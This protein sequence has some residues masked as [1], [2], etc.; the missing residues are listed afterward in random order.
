MAQSGRVILGD[1][2]AELS[3]LRSRIDAGTDKRP[4]LLFTSPPYCN[5]TNYYT[6]QWLRMWMLGGPSLPSASAGSRYGNKQTNQAKY[7]QLLEAVF[8]QARTMLTEDAVVYVR[9]DAR[10]T[11]YYPTLEVL[12]QTFSDKMIT[13]VDRPLSPDQLRKPYSRGG[14][15]K[16]ANCEVDLALLPT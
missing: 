16:R 13:Q 5:V 4:R 10:P 12:R 3:R 8:G 11:T 14:A 1:S 9:T 7:R 15:P 6:D 2:R